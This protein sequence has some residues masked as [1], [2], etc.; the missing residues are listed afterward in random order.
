MAQSDNPIARPRYTGIP[1][2]MRAPFAEDWSEV[3]I[4]MIGV[5]YDGGV[6]NRPGARH[7]PREVRN[8]SS[9]MRLINQATGVCPYDLAR[10]ADIG[11]CVIERPFQLEGAHGEIDRYYETV[12]E[13]G[14]V[15]L[16]VGGDHSISLPILRQIGK[17]GPVGMIHI[18]AHA[19]TGDDY[20]GSRF[21]HGAPFRRAA[22]EGVLDPK[23]TIQIGI[24]GGINDRDQW[25]F[26]H[27]S[28]MRVIYMHEIPAMGLDAVIA[29]ALKVAGDGPTYL[30]FDI[31]ACD[32]AYAPG[33][34]T[35][36]FGG[37]TAAEALQLLRGLSGVDFIGGD[38]VEVSPPFDPSGN[39]ALLGATILFEQLCLLAEA[40][41][42]RTV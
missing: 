19:D 32:P 6:T 2:F 18:D 24:R 40:F 34:G 20:F 9:L 36:E 33:T 38:M 16:S 39:T 28:G 14:L 30:S 21:H 4:A 35:P 29:E 22:E 41:A 10:V 11:D 26:S 8:S 25:S 3:D 17:D 31:D 7:G 23:R 12:V 1:T 5:P 13:A 42:N 37:F 15:P 27:E